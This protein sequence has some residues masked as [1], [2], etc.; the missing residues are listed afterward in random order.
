MLDPIQTGVLLSVQDEASSIKTIWTLVFTNILVILVGI[1]GNLLTLTAWP[2]SYSWGSHGRRF[3]SLSFATTALCD[4]LG[5]QLYMIITKMVVSSLAKK[6]KW[7]KIIQTSIMPVLMITMVAV[8]SPART[9]LPFLMITMMASS[10]KAAM[11]MGEEGDMKDC[12]LGAG[13]EDMKRA[14]ETQTCKNKENPKE[15]VA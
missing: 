4:F 7:M 6:G 5:I 3:P 2:Y 14:E 9:L 1:C 8:S 13:Q 11:A 10:C 15:V 12:S